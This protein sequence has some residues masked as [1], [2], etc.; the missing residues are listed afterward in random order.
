M[1]ARIAAVVTLTHQ[2]WLFVIGSLCFALGTAPG[3]AL[4]VPFAAG[5]DVGNRRVLFTFGDGARLESD[6]SSFWSHG[7]WR[8][9]VVPATL[10][11]KHGGPVTIEV[12]S[13]GDSALVV[14]AP[15]AVTTRPDWSRLF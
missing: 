6:L 10:L 5:A 12:T 7:G 1:S 3:R 11:E 14:G 2:C 9:A 4:A 8:A 15:L 13:G